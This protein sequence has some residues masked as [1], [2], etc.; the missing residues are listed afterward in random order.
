MLKYQVKTPGLFIRQDKA[1][2]RALKELGLTL[3]K[4]KHFLGR[5]SL[6]LVVLNNF[7]DSLCHGLNVL[8]NDLINLKKLSVVN[9]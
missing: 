4:G 5:F 1:I 6:E 3:N 2:G 8:S 9:L 7:V